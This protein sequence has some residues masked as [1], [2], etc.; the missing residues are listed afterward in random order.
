MSKSYTN[1][2][3]EKVENL[4]SDNKDEEL[5]R[6]IEALK[7]IEMSPQEKS[8]FELYLLGWENHQIAKHFQLGKKEVG[9]IIEDVSEKLRNAYVEKFGGDL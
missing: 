6:A 9:N 3:F 5:S 1:V 4:I 7:S 8:V 2:S